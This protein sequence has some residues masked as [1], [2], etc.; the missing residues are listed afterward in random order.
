[1]DPFEVF[2]GINPRKFDCYFK[3]T[4][5]DINSLNAKVTFICRANQLTSFHMMTTVTFN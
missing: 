4:S 5:P 1:M 3:Y 2:P